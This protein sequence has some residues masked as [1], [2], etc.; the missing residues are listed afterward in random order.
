ML[1]ARQ[2][3]TKA[4]HGQAA[5]N[6]YEQIE[7]N[8]KKTFKRKVI[9]VAETLRFWE[10]KCVLQT[11]SSIVVVTACARLKV[12]ILLSKELRGLMGLAP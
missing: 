5:D 8:K 1:G 6:G 10:V 12:C 9:R 2:L 11:G 7:M 3:L 4:A